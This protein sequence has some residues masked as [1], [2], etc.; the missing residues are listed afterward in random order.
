MEK[1]KTKMPG[2]LLAVLL[3]VVIMVVGAFIKLQNKLEELGNQLMYLQDTNS[4]LNEEI[5]SLQTNIEAALEEENS[6]IE[7]YSVKVLELDLEKR[8]Y[9][10][11]VSVVPKEYSSS[12]RT[13]VFFGVNEFPLVL[14]RYAFE[15]IIELSFSDIYDGNMTFLFSNGEKKNT[16]IAKDYVGIQTK[17]EKLLYG[18]IEKIPSYR[19]GQLIFNHLVEYSLNEYESQEY[20]SLEL[21]LMAEDEELKVVN[22]L[23]GDTVFDGEWL[24]EE[25]SERLSSEESDRQEISSGSDELISQNSDADA[26]NNSEGIVLDSRSNTNSN[27]ESETDEIAN[28]LSEVEETDTS[29][30]ET[31]TD[32]ETVTNIKETEKTLGKSGSIQFIKNV[33]IPN[34]KKIRLFL[35]A[36]NLRQFFLILLKSSLKFLQA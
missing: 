35:R 30:N 6:L 27:N 28:P 34:G 10:V 23:T 29:S 2:I 13:S 4:I 15:G 25:E 17:L 18:S 32:S 33:Q 3:I 16:E 12:T 21:V 20:Q 31:D 36:K 26:E 8:T 1:I 9:Q 22:L 14:N 24:E 5:F 11:S 7:S 19:N